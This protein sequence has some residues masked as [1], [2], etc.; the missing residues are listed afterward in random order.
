MKVLVAY[1]S[2][3]GNTEEMAEMIMER[4]KFHQC[5]TELYEIGRGSYFP[6]LENF[7]VVMLGT[8]TW[9]VGR[10]PAEV[11]DFVADVGYKPGHIAVFGSGDTQ[12][13]GDEL[14]CKAV[15]K[16]VKFYESPWE[17]LKVE[18]SPRGSQEVNVME[19]VDGIVQS[20]RSEEAAK[21]KI[22]SYS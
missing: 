12:F 14:F 10:T 16:L 13:G 21:E 11:K 19:W 18:Q 1:H 7:D 20:V 9:D 4:L 3:S 8:F 15:S 6:N 17:G 2:F 5:H 22:A